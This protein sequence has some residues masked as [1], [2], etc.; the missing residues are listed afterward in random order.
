MEARE[1]QAWQEELAAWLAAQGP[2]AGAMP[3]QAGE[4]AGQVGLVLEQARRVMAGVAATRPGLEVVDRNKHDFLLASLPRLLGFAE[5]SLAEYTYGLA[6]GGHPG[7]R[8]W[9]EE[10]D[11]AR[12]VAVLWF[13]DVRLWRVDGRGGKVSHVLLLLELGPRGITTRVDPA[14]GEYYRPEWDWARALQQ[15]LSLPILLVG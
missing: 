8:L 6:G 7:L 15:A 12:R 5:F 2:L 14:A 3:G 11:W 13:E 4:L 9:L 1:Y 10:E